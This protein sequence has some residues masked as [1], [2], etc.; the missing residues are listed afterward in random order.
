[1]ETD[2]AFA[3]AARRIVLYAVAFEVCDGAVVAF[4]RDVDDQ[5]ALGVLNGFDPVDERAQMRCDAV[6]LFEVIASW[7]EAAQGEI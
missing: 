7:A 1:M 5:D 6:D 4:D 3:G 2:A